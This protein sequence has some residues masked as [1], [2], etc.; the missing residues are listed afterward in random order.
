MFSGIVDEYNGDKLYKYYSYSDCIAE[1]FA[2]VINMTLRYRNP[3]SFNDPYDCAIAAK[4]NG[5][6]QSIRSAEMSGVYVCSLTTS[7]D[8]ILMWSHYASKHEG[9]V[10]EYDVKELKK[11]NYQ[12][13]ETFSK[14][15]YSDDISLRNLLSS[16]SDKEI[17]KA[18]YHKAGCWCYENE[19]R[20]VIY[21]MESEGPIDIKLEC[22]C[23][24]GIFLGSGFLK[25][26]NGKI[27]PF[28]Q[29]WNKDKKLY[30]MQLSYDKYKLE[31]RQD[32]LDE[33]FE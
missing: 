20:S 19:I 22:D 16:N 2:P 24:S 29:R 21:G 10:V 30:Y 7:F 13:M 14:I 33:W 8:D 9:F 18:I 11:I 1:M 17:V 15:S 32:I 31:K 3:G 12:Q 4:I 26:R 23:I 6:I 28:L 25:R 27:P 5:E